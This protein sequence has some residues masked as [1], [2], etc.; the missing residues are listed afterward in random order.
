MNLIQD[1]WYIL[2]YTLLAFLITTFSYSLSPAAVNTYPA[3]GWQTSTP[4]EQGMQSQVLANMIEEI[5][6]KGYNIDSI[7]IIRNGYMVLDAY[8]YPFSKGQRHIIRS[9]TKS[10]MSILIGIAIDRGYIKSVDQPIVELLPHNIIDSLGDNKRSITLEHLLIMA[11]GLD[12]RDS[13]HY[14]WKGLFEMRRS[15]DWGQHVL[16]LPMVRPPGSK[17]EYCNGLSHL[18]SV[19]INTTT[20]MKTREFAEKNLFTPLGISEIDWEKSPQGIDVGYGRMWLKPHDMAKIG[21]L[22]LNKGRWEKKQLVSCSWV[23]KSTRGHIEAKP[24]LQYGY[25]WWVD[26]DGNYS[27]I[28]SSGQYIM[29][30]TEMNMVVVFTGGLPVGKTSLPLELTKKYIFPAVVSSES[31]PAN[32]REAERLDQLVK[33]VSTSFSDSFVWFSREEGIAKDGIFRRAKSPKF[34][35]EYPVGSKKLSTTSKWQIMRM[36]TPNE[37]NFEASVIAIPDKIKLEDFGPKWYMEYLQ[38]IGSDAEVIANKEI[39]LNCGSRAYRTDIKWTYYDYIK[40]TSLVVSS[41]RDKK[42][43]YLVINTGRNPEKIASIVES[44]TFE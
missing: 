34:R 27:A 15:G 26:D 25:K 18:L 17:Y 28:G 10:I 32:T 2:F 39:T 16:N 21:W 7:S 38:G 19:I 41:Y 44:L 13:H 11:S 14:N 3:N 35:F 6:M 40:L 22:Y 43:V 31:L 23:E 8:F 30:A 36:K 20:K 33:S 12:C 42:C 5:K 1:K 4:E 24:A 9:C 29:V 37:A